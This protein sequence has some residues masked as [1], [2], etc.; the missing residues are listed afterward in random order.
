M[1][2]L[3]PRVHYQRLVSPA[4]YQTV[5]GFSAC[6]LGDFIGLRKNFFPKTS[7]NHKMFSLTYRVIIW[8]VFPCKGG[9]LKTLEGFRGGT[10][11]IY[12]ENED[13]WWGKGGS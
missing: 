5:A 6:N 7:G 8:Q 10:T 1:Y 9:S 13:M 2:Y 12:L 3:R 4:Q 11:Q